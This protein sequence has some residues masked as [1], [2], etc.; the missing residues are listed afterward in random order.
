MSSIM[1]GLTEGSKG[2]SFD[3]GNNSA[4]DVSLTSKSSDISQF[5]SNKLLE[6]Q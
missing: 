4:S 5:D 3:A 2:D 1:T 6:V